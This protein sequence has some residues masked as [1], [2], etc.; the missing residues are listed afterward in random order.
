M[1]LYA[2]N[3]SKNGIL[4]CYWEYINTVI[5][6]LFYNTYITYFNRMNEKMAAHML[7]QR[8]RLLHEY[9]NLKDTATMLIGI[10]R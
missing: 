9:N 7:Q 5:I 8:I 10:V 3:Y 4:F 2:M 1:K 6:K